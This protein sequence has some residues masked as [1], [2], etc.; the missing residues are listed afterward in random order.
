MT[1]CEPQIF[2]ADPVN[3]RWSVVRGDTA[4]LRVMFLEADE[5]TPLDLTGWIFESTAFNRKQEIFN[6]LDV[7]IGT[8][9]VDIIADSD[10]TESWGTGIGGRVIELI[11]D[12]QVE[13]G[14]RVWTPVLGTVSVLGDVTGGTL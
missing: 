2:G 11:F 3:V 9:Y 8:G 13:I 12:L 6:E 4:V 1:I 7:E 10:V 5:V 14:T